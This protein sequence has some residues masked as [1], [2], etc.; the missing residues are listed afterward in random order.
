MTDRSANGA[1]RANGWMGDS[2][3]CVT[4]DAM[5]AGEAGITGNGLMGC[6][7]ANGNGAIF[8]LF[9]PMQGWNPAQTDECG[10]PYKTRIHT[11]DQRLTT[12]QADGIGYIG[13]QA[14]RIFY[15]GRVVIGNRGQDRTP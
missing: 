11:R 8:N 7:G 3:R 5:A 12:C 10:R 9:N 15:G 14:N 6:H 4:Q 13:Q 2:S 1:A